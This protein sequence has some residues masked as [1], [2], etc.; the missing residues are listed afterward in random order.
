MACSIVEEK[1]GLRLRLRGGQAVPAPPR[2]RLSGVSLDEWERTARDN[3]DFII[4]SAPN[5]D[6]KTAHAVPALDSEDADQANI[7]ERCH[8]AVANLL[9]RGGC[10]DPSKL[11]G[12][13]VAFADQVATDDRLM[14]PSD[15]KTEVGELTHIT[16]DAARYARFPF[17]RFTAFRLTWT[18]ISNRRMVFNRGVFDKQTDEGKELAK[19]AAAKKASAEAAGSSS[20]VGSKRPAAA[21]ALEQCE[22]DAI[23]YEQKVRLPLLRAFA[24]SLIGVEHHSSHP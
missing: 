15:E 16:S 20:R 12:P 19:G 18:P 17:L 21:A 5:V 9:V 13:D 11:D 2:D 22:D 14:L 6:V 8:T 24:P 10:V 1:L 3:A 4:Q 7:A 23:P